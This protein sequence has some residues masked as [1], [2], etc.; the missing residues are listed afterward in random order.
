[1]QEAD[2]VR[3]KREAKAK[4]GF[5][6]EPEAKLVGALPACWAACLLRW[7]LPLQK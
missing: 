6:V 7:C 1:V 2:L 5:Y 4:A 3:L